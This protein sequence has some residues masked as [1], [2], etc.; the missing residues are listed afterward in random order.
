MLLAAERSPGRSRRTLQRRAPSR[1]L[2]RRQGFASARCRGRARCR[3]PVYYTAQT[4]GKLGIL[5]PK[6]GKYEE[7]PLGPNSAPHGVIVGPT[8]RR[9]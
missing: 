8:A 4:T 6:S 9:G 5:D 3:R 2:Q 1:V 7:I